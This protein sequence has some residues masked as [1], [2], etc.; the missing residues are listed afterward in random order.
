[1]VS[2]NPFAPDSEV[3][4]AASTSKPAP[5]SG[6][7][8]PFAAE[9]QLFAAA[10]S[11]QDPFAAQLPPPAAPR[12]SGAAAPLA[13]AHSFSE[14]GL[15]EYG[16]PQSQQGS[17]F[18]NISSTGLPLPQASANQL[19]PLRGGPSPAGSQGFQNFSSQ[20]STPTGEFMEF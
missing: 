8:D 2:G 16:R 11:Q 18:G 6:P 1:M 10:G 20:S 13:Q 17:G 4:R 14:L 19:Q 5:P 3:W 12:A 7:Q 15:T 9:P